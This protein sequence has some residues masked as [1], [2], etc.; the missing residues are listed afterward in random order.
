MKV[1]MINGS[2]NGNTATALKEIEKVFLEEGGS[3]PCPTGLVLWGMPQKLRGIP[4]RNVH[5]HATIK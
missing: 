3:Y 4:L 1:L 2:P 5:P